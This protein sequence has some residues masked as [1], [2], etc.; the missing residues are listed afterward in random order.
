MVSNAYLF[1]FISM[2]NCLVCQAHKPKRYAC[3]AHR[4]PQKMVNSLDEYGHARYTL[5]YSIQC[6]IVW[7]AT[8]HKPK[9]YACIAHRIPQKMVN[10]LDEYGHARYAIQY[11][12][13]CSCPGL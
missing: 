2:R 3:I 9:L 8:A 10:S 6:A 12:T 11:L 5:L 1:V 13:T 4:I 7:Y